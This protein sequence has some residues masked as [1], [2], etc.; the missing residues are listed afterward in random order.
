MVLFFFHYSND[1]NFHVK[2]GEEIMIFE[3]R[4]K[5]EFVIKLYMRKGTMKKCMKVIIENMQLFS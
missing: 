1:H 4:D 2:Y 3:I 5:D